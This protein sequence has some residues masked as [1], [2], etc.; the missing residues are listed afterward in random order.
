MALAPEAAGGGAPDE[1][2]LAR[3]HGVRGVAEQHAVGGG[4]GERVAGRLLPGQVLGAHHELARLHPAELGEGAVAGLIAP[5]ALGGRE[6]R[7][8]AVALLVVAV[9]AVAVDDDLVADLPALHLG[10]DLPDDAGGI[11]AGD[12]V[13]AL[14][15]VEGGDRLA[16]AGPDAVVVHAGGHDV[17]QHLVVADVPDGQHLELVRLLGRSMALAPNGPGVHLRRHVPEGRHFAHLVQVL[18]FRRARRSARGHLGSPHHFLCCSL[19]RR[20]ESRPRARTA[21]NLF[22]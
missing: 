2:V 5:D 7:V 10:A 19:Y 8:T 11:R 1:D 22:D 18:Q 4:E 6:H 12:V 9:V 14:V 17:D 20:T 15:H 13:L 3:T 21:K 16:E